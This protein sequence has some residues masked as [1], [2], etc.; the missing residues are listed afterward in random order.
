MYRG[1]LI[2]PALEKCITQFKNMGINRV[3][4]CWK[5]FQIL[6]PEVREPIYLLGG[7]EKQKQKKT[8]F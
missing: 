1:Y 7:R 5:E 4:A 2:S 3:I 6:R 8:K